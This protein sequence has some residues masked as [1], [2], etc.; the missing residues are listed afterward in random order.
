MLL[1]RYQRI[2][3]M[4]Q[5]CFILCLSSLLITILSSCTIGI[6]KNSVDAGRQV[7]NLETGSIID[8]AWS[9]LGDKIAF[10]NKRIGES[11]LLVY[12][13]SS[14]TLQELLVS[15]NISVS[16]WSPVEDK[17]LFYSDGNF[18]DQTLQA[19]LWVIDLNNHKL[20]F[21]APGE[22]GAWSPDGTIVAVLRSS[23]NLVSIDLVQVS[24]GDESNI[25]SKA[26]VNLSASDISWSPDGSKLLFALDD[27][28]E[29]GKDLYILDIANLTLEKIT[30]AGFNYSASWSP[31]AQLIAYVSSRLEWGTSYVLL[32][33]SDTPDCMKIVDGTVQAAYVA[34]SPNGD[35]AY[36][37][38]NKMFLLDHLN[39]NL[40]LGNCN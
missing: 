19:G 36:S 27:S 2:L 6:P 29:F 34:F 33:R 23:D 10:S 37:R 20:D 32:A 38:Q 8:I 14:D 30:T 15:G 16:Q 26:G 24:S 7:I 17:L 28:S 13:L 5:N 18:P 12:D 31:D 3:K 21:F 9:P 39:N 40:R 22:S 11:R 1:V 25:L 35:L 4:K